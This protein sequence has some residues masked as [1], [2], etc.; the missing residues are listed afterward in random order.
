M[1]VLVTHHRGEIPV[2]DLDAVP[3]DFGNTRLIQ[4]PKQRSTNLMSR[5]SAHYPIGLIVLGG[6]AIRVGVKSSVIDHCRAL[7]LRCY[8]GHNAIPMPFA[9]TAVK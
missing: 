8:L 5:S 7:H 4:S 6:V 1:I 9:M 2:S 3:L